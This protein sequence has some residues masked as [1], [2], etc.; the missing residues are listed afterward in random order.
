MMLNKEM[1]P[2]EMK[3]A[4]PWK[5]FLVHSAEVFWHDFGSPYFG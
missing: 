1:L 5:D 4:L 3:M 2:E